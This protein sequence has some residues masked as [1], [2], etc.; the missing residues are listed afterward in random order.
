MSPTLR[1]LLAYYRPYAGKL[2]IA[3]LMMA[4]ASAIPGALV[5]LVEKV[6]D[7][8]LIAQDARALAAMPFLVVGLYLANG[9]LGVG[10]AMITKSVAFSVVTT[11]R[12][13]LH[14]AL[15]GLDAGWHQVR[16][17]GERLTGLTQDV[18]QVEYLVSAYA[19]AVQKPL[20]LLMLLASALY[21]DWQLTLIALVVLPFVALPIAHFGRRLR[22]RAAESLEGLGQLTAV[23]QE[24]LAGLRTLQLLAAEPIAQARFERWN[25]ELYS[26][27]MALT[28]ARLL[29][30]P[31]VEL[32]AALAVG[33]VIAFGGRRVFAGETSP[34]E[35][36]A[37]L[38]AMG[39]MNLPLKGLA[40][41]VS[42]T[43]RALAG[44][45]RVF[46][47]V[48]A[49][50]AVQ[51]GA[52][53]L[54]AQ[55]CALAWEGVSVDY[56]DGPV[57]EAV[58]LEV[59]PG[60]RLALAGASGAG[61]TT[62]LSLL[63]RV[64]DPSA[65]RVTLNGEDVR[66]YTLTS[67]RRHVAVV[68]QEPWLFHASVAE[69]LRLARPEASEPE[70]RAACEAANAW[71]FVSELPSG[72]DT[73]LDEAGQRLSGG[74]RQRLCIARALLQDAP[75]LILDEA[76]SALDAESERAVQE[77]LERLMQGRTVLI[78]AHRRRTLEAA[79][80]VV[81]LSG[82]GVVQAGS[83]AALAAE[84]GEYGRLFGAPVM[85][86]DAPHRGPEAP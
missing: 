1:R 85:E 33:G 35:L 48:D 32:I 81:V 57:L 27:Q 61:K 31:V 24:H 84:G 82:G 10:R 83:H 36:I 46:A 12:G 37:F 62:L 15:L 47:V 28:L 49:T 75:V 79:E 18:G 60:E 77:A 66:R 4:L 39:L 76:T 38:V 23:S 42:L 73:V 63:P 54:H 2:A 55:A 45:E 52:L 53:E 70:L 17:L 11:L 43:Q 69:N 21:M 34:G 13:E 8:V 59:A 40:E 78:I 50:P 56:G 80:R 22:A 14:A 30:G 6:L 9:L 74:Q 41:I 71:G 5:L 68:P 20:T 25:Q 65:G 44:A 3:T 16:P 72:L 26:R 19:T 64:R 51:G 86:D 7:E 67:L 58:S 29:P